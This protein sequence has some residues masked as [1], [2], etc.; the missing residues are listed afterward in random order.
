MYEKRTVS[1]KHVCAMLI[2]AIVIAWPLQMVLIKVL[3]VYSLAFLNYELSLLFVMILVWLRENGNPWLMKFHTVL[4]SVLGWFGKYTL[5]LY[6][7]HV[8]IRKVMKAYGYPTYRLVYE[9]VLAGL[10]IILSIFLNKIAGAIQKKSTLD[11]RAEEM[12]SK[13][14]EVLGTYR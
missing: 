6:L 9:G 10:S 4:T 1:G 2:L 3:G 8:M 11:K 5:E 13:Q 14:Y 7:I 12:R